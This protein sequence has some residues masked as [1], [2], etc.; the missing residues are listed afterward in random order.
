MD[1]EIDFETCRFLNFNLYSVAFYIIV[2]T[3]IYDKFSFLSF[4]SHRIRFISN[5]EFSIFSG[6]FFFPS[7]IFDIAFYV[8]FLFSLKFPSSW[9]SRITFVFSCTFYIFSPTNIKKKKKKGYIF[10]NNILL[11]IFLRANEYNLLFFFQIQKI[12]SNIKRLYADFITRVNYIF[13]IL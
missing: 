13:K 4:I 8:T 5:I 7:I 3:R 12:L 11:R 1:V 2:V 6:G 10:Y 9:Q